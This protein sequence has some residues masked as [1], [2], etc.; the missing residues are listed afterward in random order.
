MY[1]RMKWQQIYASRNLN[2]DG[3]EKYGEHLSQ[4]H[5]LTITKKQRKIVSLERHV[6]AKYRNKAIT[7]FQPD[8]YKNN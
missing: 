3:S 1:S 5:V 2:M 4:T 7:R 8:T 6:L